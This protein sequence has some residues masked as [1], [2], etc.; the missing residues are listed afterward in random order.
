[1]LDKIRHCR[2][3]I[4]LFLC[5]SANGQHCFDMVLQDH[6]GVSSVLGRKNRKVRG[7]LKSRSSTL[8]WAS[9]DENRSK[10]SWSRKGR[11]E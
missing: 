4:R 1:M 7:Q 9:E 5:S 2:N 8:W 10:G 3:G 6:M 11:C